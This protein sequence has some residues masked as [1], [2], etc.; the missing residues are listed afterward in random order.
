MS[1]GS[2]DRALV[3]TC[4]RPDYLKSGAA[5]RGHLPRCAREQRIAYELL[6]HF[7]ECFLI[8]RTELMRILCADG[9]D[10]MLHVVLLKWVTTESATG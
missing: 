4:G 5:T 3:E 2:Q 8:A 7:K 6:D 9:A 1:D 10:L